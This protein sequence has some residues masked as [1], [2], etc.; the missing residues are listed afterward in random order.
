MFCGQSSP[1]ECRMGWSAFPYPSIGNPISPAPRRIKSY[2]AR[3]TQINRHDERNDRFQPLIHVQPPN[4]LF[5]FV[6]FGRF[7]VFSLQGT[8]GGCPT[9]TSRF[10]LESACANCEKRGDGH[11]YRWPM[12]LELIAVISVT[13][14]K[15]R[16]TSAYRP[17]RFSP[18]D[19]RSACRS[20]F[21]DYRLAKMLVSM[22]CALTLQGERQSQEIRH[23]HLPRSARPRRL[24]SYPRLP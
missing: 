21:L 11:R 20:S 22:S 1:V 7:I 13:W 23:L 2:E 5:F 9:K 17:L 14:R 8:I 15:E 18:W 10:A 19:S 24:R 12:R 4:R 16:R 3:D 6:V